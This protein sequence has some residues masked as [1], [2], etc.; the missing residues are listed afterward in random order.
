LSDI[1]IL[2]S[3][4]DT[5]G[6]SELLWEV[7]TF[8]FSYNPLLPLKNTATSFLEPGAGTESSLLLLAAP[9]HYLFVTEIILQGTLKS[10]LPILFSPDADVGTVVIKR[11]QG[12]TK[13]DRPENL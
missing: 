10:S 5:I 12:M 3:Y 4:S 9:Q 11:F 1:P 13:Q 7:P 2:L 8:V 6:I